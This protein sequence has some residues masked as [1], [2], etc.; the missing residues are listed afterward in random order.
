MNRYLDKV[1]LVTGA[2][3]GIGRATAERLAAEGAQLMLADINAAGLREVAQQL[4]ASGNGSADR[5]GCVTYDAS[6]DASCRDMVAA[7]ISR[8]G[9]L[10]VL[11]NI[12]GIAGAAKFLEMTREEW[13]RML[14]VNLTSLFTVSQAALPHLIESRGNIVNMASASGKMGSPYFSHYAASKAAVISLTQSLAVEFSV[15]GVRVN[16]ICPGGVA[17]PI[18]N[19]YKMPGDMN[20]DLLKR[21]FALHPEG[22]PDEIAAAVAYLGSDEARYISGHALSI[23]GAQTA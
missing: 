14:A 5:V 1:C 19:T 6:D 20:M 4:S 7:T 23:D 15:E 16:A 11:C 17:T 8:F 12:A 9:R 2:A 13:D 18:I 21:L 10:D 3:S 22:R